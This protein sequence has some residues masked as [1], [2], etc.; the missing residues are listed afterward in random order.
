M[1]ES[2]DELADRL[3]NALIPSYRGRLLDRG[4]ARN[5]IWED[6]VLPNEAPPFAKTL[7]EDLL[8]YGYSILS[9]A[10][11]LR[12]L[13]TG[14]PVLER[15]F[16]VAGEAFEAAVH[17]GKAAGSQGFHRVS[18]AVAFHLARY[19]ARAFSILPSE[20]ESLNLSPTEKVLVHLHSQYFLVGQL[21]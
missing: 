15:S 8:D 18:A 6:G 20:T 5:L 12:M 4:L 10:L 3:S 13:N 1:E 14:H 2:E 17:R 7:T 21:K 16:R 9:M 19:S 11:R